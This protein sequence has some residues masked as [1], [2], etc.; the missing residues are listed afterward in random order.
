MG[1]GSS[2]LSYLDADQLADRYLAIK[3]ELDTAVHNARLLNKKR[4]LDFALLRCWF[5]GEYEELKPI[6]RERLDLVEEGG[7]YLFK[8]G[9]YRSKKECEELGK[10]WHIEI[11]LRTLRK[12]GFEVTYPETDGFVVA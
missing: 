5:N 1:I 7:D 9:R 2:P 6:L 8:A 3:R 4:D 11:T 10:T 12:L